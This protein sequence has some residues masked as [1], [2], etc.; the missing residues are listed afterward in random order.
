M[1]R[2]ENTFRAPKGVSAFKTITICELDGTRELDAKQWAD[3]RIAKE[4]VAP[5]DLARRWQ[6]ER[7]EDVRA[8][9]V[10]VDDEPVNQNGAPFAAFDKWPKKVKRIVVP[11]FHDAM[12][13]VDT[14]DLEKCVSEV[15]NPTHLAEKKEGAATDAHKGG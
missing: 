5:D 6:I 10:A 11:R 3:M 8:S 13:A 7:E 12:N 2:L 14:D 1:A 4:K 15:M 9:I